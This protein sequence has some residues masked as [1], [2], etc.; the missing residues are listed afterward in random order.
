MNQQGIE[1]LP[2]FCNPK[3]AYQLTYMLTKLDVNPTILEAKILQS[4]SKTKLHLMPF[5]ISF[6]TFWYT[7]QGVHIICKT[8][9][10]IEH[11]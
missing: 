2:Q 11:M 7:I 5:H 4:I 1:I 9:L 3:K 8:S 6:N 10:Q